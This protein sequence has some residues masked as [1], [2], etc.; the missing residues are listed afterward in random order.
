MDVISPYRK[1]P[2]NA[3]SRLAQPMDAG[4]RAGLGFERAAARRVEPRI[5]GAGSDI[6]KRIER[7]HVDGIKSSDTIVHCVSTRLHRMMKVITEIT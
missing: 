2:Y 7:Y 1:P 3:V 6:S 4:T 5:G